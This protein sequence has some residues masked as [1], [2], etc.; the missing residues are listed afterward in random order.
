MIAATSARTTRASAPAAHVHRKMSVGDHRIAYKFRSPLTPVSRFRSGQGDPDDPIAA[1]DQHTLQTSGHVPAVARN[2]CASLSSHLDSTDRIH[3]ASVSRSTR[4]DLPVR[5]EPGEPHRGA[6][7]RHAFSSRPST[8]VRAQAVVV[9]GKASAPR[10]PLVPLRSAQR[11]VPC[12]AHHECVC[13]WRASRVR[14]ARFA[15]TSCRRQES[16][17]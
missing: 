15:G 4:P 14:N 9:D 8:R 2:V 6:A 1:R 3:M 11:P 12:V 16:N 17:L 10:A 7:G 13:S 5:M